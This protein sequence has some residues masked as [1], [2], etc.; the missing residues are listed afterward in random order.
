MKKPLA[1][2]PSTYVMIDLETLAL[3]PQACVLQIGASAWRFQDD[4]DTAVDDPVEDTA[5]RALDEYVNL[6]AQIDL[7]RII[8]A[9]TIGF[10][11][12]LGS[13]ILERSINCEL[14]LKE[15]LTRFSAFFFDLDDFVVLSRGA[16]F[17][18]PIIESLMATVGIA[19]PWKYNQVWDH[20]TIVN[21]LGD[22]GLERPKTYTNHDGYWDARFQLRQLVAMFEKMGRGHD[23]PQPNSVEPTA[24]LNLQPQK[25]FK[26]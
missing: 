11:L 7:G 12:G 24:K 20:R 16:A 9:K 19:C 13:H 2:L 18:F 25:S 8:N 14:S 21:L 5:F 22:P 10:H 4:N 15:T 6:Q 26:V 1:H 3:V 17:D 23:D